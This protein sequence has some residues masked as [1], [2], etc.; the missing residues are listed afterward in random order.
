MA[1]IA[2]PDSVSRLQD[3]TMR[4]VNG[5]RLEIVVRPPPTLQKLVHFAK[6]LVY[7]DKVDV[8]CGPSSS[9]ADARHHLGAKSRWLAAS[10]TS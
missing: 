4:R 5:R 2:R 8:V 7:N 3:L 1:G 10:S 6:E 9:N